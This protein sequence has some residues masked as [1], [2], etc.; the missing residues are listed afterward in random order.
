MIS[1]MLCAVSLVSSQDFPSLPVQIEKRYFI[2]LNKGPKRSLT[3]TMPPKEVSEMQAKHLANFGRLDGLGKLI[4]VGPLTDDGF[5]RGIIA[6]KAKSRSEF[7]EYFAP[8]PYIEH[9]ILALDAYEMGKATWEIIAFSAETKMVSNS[10]VI[11]KKG[12]NWSRSK[13][14]GKFGLLPSE[15][16]WSKSGKLAFWSRLSGGSDPTVVG[17]LYFHSGKLE[18]VTEWVKSDSLVSGGVYVA[19]PHPQFMASRFVAS[20]PN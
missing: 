8:D 16:D 5:I 7:K 11:L 12:P 9:E 15:T 14:S 2:L 18:E 13:S 1:A 10:I 3:S 20:K 6:V 17:L 4:F 19:E